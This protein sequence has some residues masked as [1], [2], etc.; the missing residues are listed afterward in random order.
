MVPSVP[1]TLTYSTATASPGQ[2][3]EAACELRPEW[4]CGFVTLGRAQ[5][6]FGEPAMALKS[7]QRVIQSGSLLLLIRCMLHST[8]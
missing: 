1:D 7:F 4:E 2:A 8:P 5:L 6:N 3:A